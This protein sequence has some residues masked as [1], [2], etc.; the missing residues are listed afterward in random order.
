MIRTILLGNHVF[1]Q[2]DFVRDLTDG[3]IL[4]R[5]GEKLFKGMPVQPRTA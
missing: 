2:G 1:V 4:V 5:V 3:R